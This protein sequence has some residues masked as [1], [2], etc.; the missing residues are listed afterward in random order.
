MT[1]KMMYS[2]DNA[3]L[4]DCDIT[5]AGRSAVPSRTEGNLP[6]ARN[7]AKNSTAAT[8]MEITVQ[9]LFR[10][11][12]ARE[13]TSAK[14]K[15]KIAGIS[16]VLC[17]DPVRIN[18]AMPRAMYAAPKTKNIGEDANRPGRRILDG[19]QV[20]KKTKLRNYVAMF[21]VDSST[22]WARHVSI[23]RRNEESEDFES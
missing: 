5:A 23:L 13:P 9:S 7:V 20:K 12:T 11:L 21:V 10:D 16:A 18:P 6:R 1:A 8:V 22:I 14:T 4:R 15:P 2:D 3:A 19:G 17:V